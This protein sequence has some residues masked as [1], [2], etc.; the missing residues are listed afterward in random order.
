[1]GQKMSGRFRV[2][3]QSST[4]HLAPY[5][6]DPHQQVTTDTESGF[7][8]FFFSNTPPHNCDSQPLAHRLISCLAHDDVGLTQAGRVT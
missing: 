6:S 4:I 5:S 2:E 7:S 1:M 8:F 3:K